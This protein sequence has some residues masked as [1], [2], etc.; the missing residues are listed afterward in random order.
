MKNPFKLLWLMIRFRRPSRVTEMKAVCENFWLSS[1]YTAMTFFGHI[2]VHSIKEAEQLN[3]HALDMS[4]LKRHE[5]IHLRQ[6]QSTH[7]SWFCFYT[8]YIWYYLRALP[9]NRYMHNAAY[10][11]NPFEMEAYRHMYEHDYLEKCANGANEWRVYAKMKPSERRKKI[12]K[13]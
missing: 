13:S 8:L 2:V 12:A 4:S 10:Y 3:G 1:N 6:A 5:T 11:L 9:Q 7:N